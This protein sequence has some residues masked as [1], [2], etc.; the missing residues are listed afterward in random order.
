MGVMCKPGRVLGADK[1]TPQSVCQIHAYKTGESSWGLG[2]G[3]QRC[4]QKR[5]VSHL[6]GQLRG[7]AKVCLGTSFLSPGASLEE[8][9]S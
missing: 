6:L 7:M 5:V 2:Q 8:R 1:G 4:F 3:F 9:D